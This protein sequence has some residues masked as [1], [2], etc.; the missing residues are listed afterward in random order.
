[1]QWPGGRILQRHELDAFLAQAVSSQLYEPDQLQEL[2]VEKVDSRGVQL[3]S[4]FMA[5]VD[6]ALFINDVCG[7]P[8]P[9]EHCCPWGFFDG[10]LF[11]SK[12]ARAARDR[13]ALL[14]MC[15]GQEELV[16]KVE[17]MRQAILEGINLSR[18]PP[19]PPPLPPPPF[20]RFH[21]APFLPHA[22]LYPPRPM[23]MPHH[24]HPHILTTPPSTDQEPSQS[25]PPQG[26]KLEIAGMVVGQWAGNKPVRGRGGFNMQVVSVGAGRGRGKEIPAKPR[27]VKKTPTNRSQTSPPPPSSSPPKP[28]EEAAGSPEAAPQ[29]LNGSA[30]AIGPPLELA[31]PAQPIPCALARDN[32]S[33]GVEVEAPC[34]LD[35]CP[36]DGALQKEE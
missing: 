26:G 5:G 30:A 8:L 17:K 1:M 27:V 31:P 29:Q 25:I 23:G 10:K 28:S 3:A 15:E 6:T 32:Q 35:D 36:S 34:C 16:S 13:A 22:P 9:W 12:L 2:K 18:P 20:P 14:D 7:Q 21:G 24:H 33:D 11:Q 4:L 19:P